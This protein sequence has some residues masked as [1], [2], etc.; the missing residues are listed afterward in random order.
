MKVFISYRFTGEVVTELQNMLSEIT[1]SLEIA[2]HESWHSMLDETSF[3][4]KN[5]TNKQIMDHSLTRLNDADVFLAVVKSDE[6][7]EGML[8][9]IGYAIAKGKPFIL[10]VKEGV[11]TTSIAQMANQVIVFKDLDELYEK[12]KTVRF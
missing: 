3:R 11:K 8:V 10:A 1:K 2:T 7:S 5:F 12:L 9:E 6:K 4:Q